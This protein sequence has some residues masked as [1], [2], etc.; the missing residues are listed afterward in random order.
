MF[1]TIGRYRRFDIRL[2]TIDPV[3]KWIS[4]EWRSAEWRAK[5][6]VRL[7]QN[8]YWPISCCFSL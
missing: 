7:A 5:E 3:P 8:E 6:A 2:E 4:R 1:S